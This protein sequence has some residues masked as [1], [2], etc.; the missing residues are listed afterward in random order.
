MK[1][2]GKRKS[3]RSYSP[4]RLWNSLHVYVKTSFSVYIPSKDISKLIYFY[5]SSVTTWRLPAH[6]IPGPNPGALQRDRSDVEHCAPMRTKISTDFPVF[7]NIVRGG[8]NGRPLMQWPWRPLGG[9]ALEASGPRGPWKAKF[10]L[11]IAKS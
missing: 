3:F 10:W 8:F 11:A 1:V 6:L 9:W 5:N 2:L 7:L 4:H